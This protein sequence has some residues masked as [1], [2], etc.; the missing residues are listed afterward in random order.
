MRYLCPALFMLVYQITEHK[1][2]ALVTELPVRGAVY[3]MQPF[4][5]KLVAGVDSKIYLYSWSGVDAAGKGRLSV[6]CDHHGHIIA[7]HTAVRGDFIVVG[8]LMKSVSLLVYKPPTAEQSEPRL[9]E[10]AK[11]IPQL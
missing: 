5:G 1:K 7:L 2:L 3:T 4:H 8:D 11:V 10:V 6:D 9:E